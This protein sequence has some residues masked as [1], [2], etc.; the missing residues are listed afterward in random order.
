MDISLKG[1][2][3][4]ITAGGAGIGR[5]IARHFVADGARV[6]VCDVAEGAL[7]ETRAALPGIG[8]TL[9]DVSDAAQVDK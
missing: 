4:V 2:R 8:A 5:A 6:H 1:L 9:A 7:A 3:V